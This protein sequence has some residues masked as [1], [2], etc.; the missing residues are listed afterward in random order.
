MG[1]TQV[2]RNAWLTQCSNILLTKKKSKFGGDQNC[3][4]QCCQQLQYILTSKINATFLDSSE[5]LKILKMSHFFSSW[6]NMCQSVILDHPASKHMV[7]N[8]RPAHITINTVSKSTLKLLMANSTFNLS[9][10]NI[11][12]LR[13]EAA[14][15]FQT[16]AGILLITSINQSSIWLRQFTIL[17][18]EEI[19]LPL[20]WKNVT[21]VVFVLK[22]KF[23]N[24]LAAKISLF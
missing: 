6:V 1:H 24:K 8:H 19:T 3:S 20:V 22:G 5:T 14:W 11:R 7:P 13:D 18:P 9:V 21:F 4:E 17:Y 12:H 15:I 2:L 16:V 10:T 23:S